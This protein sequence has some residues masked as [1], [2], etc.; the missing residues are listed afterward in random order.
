MGGVS[1]CI[2]AMMTYAI[3]VVIFAGIVFTMNT[4]SQ[5]GALRK[6][7]IS[8]MVS[9]IAMISNVVYMS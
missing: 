7:P 8:V 9:A 6:A 1:I 2:V 5:F 3:L 4:A